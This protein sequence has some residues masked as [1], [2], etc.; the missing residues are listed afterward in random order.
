MR[1]SDWSSNGCSSDIRAEDRRKDVACA[2]AL[3][4]EIEET[5]ALAQVREHSVAIGAAV[6][7]PGPFADTRNRALQRIVEQTE[8]RRVGEECVSTCRARWAPYHYK[9]KQI[10]KTNVNVHKITKR[11]E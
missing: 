9:K 6:V 2:T 4:V 3:R 5:V 8:E 11:Q 10:K 7:E 1:I